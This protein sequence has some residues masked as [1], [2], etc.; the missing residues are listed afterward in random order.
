[1]QA[2][3]FLSQDELDFIQ[4]MQHSPQLNLADPCRTCWSMATVV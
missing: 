4:N 2:D 1:M 3:A